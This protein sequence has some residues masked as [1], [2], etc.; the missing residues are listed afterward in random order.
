MIEDIEKFSAEL[1]RRLF[2]N[3]SVL[4]QG[5][6]DVGK[7]GPPQRPP[8]QISVGSGRWQRERIRI[9]PLARIA[10]DDSTRKGCVDVRPIR[11]PHVA[12]PGSIRANQRGERETGEKCSDSVQLP[13]G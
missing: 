10:R 6:V 12:V 1:Q 2:V 9:E 3:R 5:E 8:A 11:V 13:A 4:E 7:T